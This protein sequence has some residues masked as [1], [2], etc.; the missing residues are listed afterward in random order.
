MDIKSIFTKK[1]LFDINPIM[2]ENVDKLFGVVGALLIVLAAVLKVAA[3]FAPT[4]VDREYRN[5]L[6]A[7]FLTTGVLEIIW[8]GLRSQNVRV[9]GTHFMALL[10]LLVGLVWFVLIVKDFVKKYRVQKE[11]WE[12]EQVRMKYLPK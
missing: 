12:K 10:I 1:F 11:T 2:I 8:Y 7:M 6:F 5:R 3:M 9:F 4:P